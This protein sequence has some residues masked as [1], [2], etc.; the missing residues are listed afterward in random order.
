MVG[1]FDIIRG[2]V[3]GVIKLIQKNKKTDK[4]ENEE[5]DHVGEEVTPEPDLKSSE[6]TEEIDW[7]KSRMNSR[8]TK[9]LD[10]ST[11]NLF[12]DLVLNDIL[13]NDEE[14]NYIIKCKPSEDSKHIPKENEWFVMSDRRLLLVS[15]REI[16]LDYTYDQVYEYEKD[17]SFDDDES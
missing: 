1:V 17:E 15:G 9:T 12:Q 13:D 10:I 2:K 8:R 6:A 5:I 7:I 14:L 3:N 16:I 4:I 11:N